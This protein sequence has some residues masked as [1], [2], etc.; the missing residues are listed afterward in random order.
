MKKWSEMLKTEMDV[1]MFSATHWIAIAWCYA[2][3]RWI[4]KEDGVN[5]FILTQMGIVAYLM[6]WGQK[7]LFVNATLYKKITQRWRRVLWVCIPFT[8]LIVAQYIFHWF[9]K[10]E[11]MEVAIYDAMLLFFFVVVEI[12]I[13]LI[14]KEDTKVLN[15]LLQE[16]QGENHKKD[17]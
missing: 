7:L 11:W 1:E 15:D 2:F 3:I 16:Y 17:I 8:L 9:S 10:K 6:S 5:F 12:L 13:H 4:F 14:Y